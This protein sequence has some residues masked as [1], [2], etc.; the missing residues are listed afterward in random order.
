MK[1]NMM[2]YIKEYDRRTTFHGMT[3]QQVREIERWLVRENERNARFVPPGVWELEVSPTP[4][5]VE[6][7]RNSVR[8]N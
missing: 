6:I 7:L 8:R 2:T 5:W 4:R 3:A 1:G